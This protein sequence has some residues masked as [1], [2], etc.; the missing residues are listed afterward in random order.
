MASHAVDSSPTIA[1]STGARFQAL[2]LSAASLP[3]P[4]TPL[5]GRSRELETCLSLLASRDV[6][7][8]TLTGPGGVGKTRLAIETATRAASSSTKQ[9]AFVELSTISD[10][11]MVGEAIFQA[12]GGRAGGRDYSPRRL[13]QLVAHADLLLVLD[14]FEQV[15]QGASIV[16]A[17]LDAGPH[18]KILVTSR[19]SL[20][21]TGE[22]ELS[23]PPLP[24]EVTPAPVRA[25]DSLVSEAVS[26]FVSRAHAV[27][28]EFAPTPEDLQ[29]IAET[30]QRLDG[31]PLAIELAAARMT[32]LSPQ[33]L[34]HRIDLHEVGR[35]RLLTGGARDLPERQQTMRNAIAWSYD[36]LTPG[37]RELFEGLSSFTG[38]F[39][40]DAAEA[41]TGRSEDD[42]L[43]GIAS[44]VA[45][46]LV[47][48]DGDPGGEPRYSM[49][50][51]IREFGLH[52]LNESGNEPATRSRHA[53]WCLALAI[54]SGQKIDGPEAEIWLD[55]FER[56]YANLRSALTW[57]RDNGH[58][59]QFLRLAVK[60]MLF[61]QDRA[62]YSEGRRWLESA[63]A[64]SP[65]APAGARMRAM[66]GAGSLAWYQTDV[67]EAVRW[68]EQALAL[69]RE[70]GDREVESLSL[71]NL[72]A[73]ATEV[74]D[75]DR[76]VA[77]YEASL[78]IA[79]ESGEPTATVLALHNLAHVTALREEPEL[80]VT[81]FEEALSLAR[82]F[83]ITWIQ[84]T[85]LNGLAATL[86]DLGDPSQALSLH[87]EALHLAEQRGNVA[88]IVDG[89][90]GVARIAAATGQMT[91]AARLIGAAGAV[92]VEIDMPLS[93]TE[94]AS[95]EPVITSIHA[96]IGPKREAEAMA[97]GRALTRSEAI[98]AAS[99]VA[100]NA[101]TAHG[102]S[103]GAHG[104][105][106]RE[107]DVLRLL[108]AGASD[109]EIGEALFISRATASRHV[110]NIFNKLGVDSRVKT[111]TTA[112]ELGLLD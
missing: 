80:A 110:A 107:M 52:R 20:E 9:V 83:E 111:I 27:F 23:V 86:L 31:L 36:L 49:L 50:A 105:T 3:T 68:H 94:L 57:L 41:V 91:E 100:V 75:Y 28:A 82:Q 99:A 112:K 63:L 64:M 16:R 71:S 87:Q 69:A 22:Y 30:C 43:D 45:K 93:P 103:Q 95:I 65:D 18:L 39:T 104:L 79:R 96:A 74:G 48:Y 19:V 21:L 55:A 7:L 34:L 1:A 102:R 98:A 33:A 14:N 81:R 35:L 53:D 97:A 76:A 32:H 2:D 101:P 51:T 89:L 72:G 40:L 61:W 42:T 8:V 67:A 77:S 37:E 26:L 4:R 11:M 6:Q 62:Y 106:T 5:I 15:V 47:R 78:A 59:A 12:L 54:E 10:P 108:A 29:T 109:R 58:G 25:D 66:S 88:D 46:S 73:Q 92:R 70:T 84:S 56:E 38:G 17:L 60:L 44:L 85:T 90:E 13:E 24:V